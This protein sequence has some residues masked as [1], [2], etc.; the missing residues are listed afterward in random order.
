MVAEEMRNAV[1]SKV[2][3]CGDTTFSVTISIGIACMKGTKAKGFEELIKQAD[4]ALYLAKNSGR[5]R[6]CI[7]S[8]NED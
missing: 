4:K 6:T 7:F 3:T 5:N 2:F 8:E 1:E